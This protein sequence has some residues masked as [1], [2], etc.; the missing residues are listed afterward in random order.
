MIRASDG[1][2]PGLWTCMLC[3]KR[4][5]DEKI[6][7]SRSRVEA[8]VN[9]GAGFDTRAY[10]LPALA[11]VPVWELD[12]PGTIRKKRARL[13]EIFGPR[14]AAGWFSRMSSG[15]FWRGKENTAGKK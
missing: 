5:I 4:Y 6:T 11:G 12:Q 1:S 2:A 7:E 3:R 9:L 15:I 13:N 14:R 10:R 8:A